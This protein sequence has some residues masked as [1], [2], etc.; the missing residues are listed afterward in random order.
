[1]QQISLTAPDI[2]CA[3]CQQ[4]VEREVGAMPGVQSVHVDVPTQRVDVVYDPGQTSE[5]QIVAVLDEAGY[6]VAGGTG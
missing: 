4:T 3:H 2:S 6:P 1:M 5:T